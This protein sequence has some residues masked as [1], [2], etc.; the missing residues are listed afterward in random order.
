[1]VVTWS[2]RSFIQCKI[3]TA[4]ATNIDTQINSDGASSMVGKN[5]LVSKDFFVL[6]WEGW[7]Y[8][9]LI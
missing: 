5:T 6:K 4:I 8:L 2:T 1:M 9:T 3:G 7:E